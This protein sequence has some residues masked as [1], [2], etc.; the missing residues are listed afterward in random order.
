VK[1]ST[2]INK[3][4]RTMKNK[5]MINTNKNNNEL[6]KFLKIIKEESK[7]NAVGF[8]DIH[9]IAKNKKSRTI[10]RKEEFIR[11]IRKKRFKASSTHFSGTGVRSNISYDKLLMLLKE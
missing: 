6:L 7:I 11:K 2:I 10:V 3:N 9:Q 8:Y 1:I 4:N 5:T